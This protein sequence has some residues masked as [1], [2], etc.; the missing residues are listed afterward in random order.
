M[1]AVSAGRQRS[2]EELDA[3]GAAAGW[4]RTALSPTRTI[5][6]LLELEAI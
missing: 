4:R 6:S 5:D 3:L 1:L 2:L